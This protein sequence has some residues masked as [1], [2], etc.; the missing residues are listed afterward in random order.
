M[1]STPKIRQGFLNSTSS[2]SYE[3]SGLSSPT[4]KN[5]NATKFAGLYVKNTV[6]RNSSLKKQ[7]KKKNVQENLH[8][9]SKYI[10]NIPITRQYAAKF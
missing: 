4:L 9:L 5:A 2:V 8:L 7:K 1:T 3:W 6:L 10:P